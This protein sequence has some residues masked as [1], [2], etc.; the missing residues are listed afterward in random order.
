MFLY[1]IRIYCIQR[2]LVDKSA[3]AKQLICNKFCSNIFL[4]FINHLRLSYTCNNTYNIR[5]VRTNGSKTL[6]ARSI[7]KGE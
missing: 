7:H 2:S 6:R 5:D 4:K 1:F 3:I